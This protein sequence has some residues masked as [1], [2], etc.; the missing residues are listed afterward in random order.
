[1]GNT[2]E[3]KTVTTLLVPYTV[4]S[5]LKKTI[6][7]AEDKYSDLIGG[8]RV[9]VI[10]KGG[11]SLINLLGRNDPWAS[12]RVC[13]DK[14]CMPCTSRTWLNEEKKMAKKNKTKLPEVLTTK[15]SNQCRREGVNYSLQ[16]LDCA[17]QGKVAKYTGESSRSARQRQGE[18]NKDLSQ[19][20]T[21]SPIVMHTIEE[22]A[23]I[24][25]QILSVID[26]IEP[27]ALYRTVRESVRIS[28]MGQ[29]KGNLNRCQ[30]WGT[31]RIPILTTKG[32]DNS[33]TNLGETNEK[34]TVSK[35]DLENIKGSYSK[36]GGITFGGGGQIG[37][38]KQI[39][40]NPKHAESSHNP[41][42]P[43]P[44]SQKPTIPTPPP[45][46]P[47]FGHRMV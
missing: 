24:K 28:N 9:R 2:T 18:H 3:K 14:D 11:D 27:R 37:Q 34:R 5:K 4:G 22:H 15:T 23:G 26:N 36:G 45:P 38:K 8:K 46:P 10:E 42:H 31:P 6:Q 12:K 33:G 19:G 21:T 39:G 30:E 43:P 29:G 20:Q 32:G 25:P 41:P 35:T 44:L 7:E 47:N 16:C 1:M 40:Q 13:T 17:I